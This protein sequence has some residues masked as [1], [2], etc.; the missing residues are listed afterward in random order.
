MRLRSSDDDAMVEEVSLSLQGVI[1]RWVLEISLCSYST[2][3]SWNKKD[4]SQQRNEI[5]HWLNP[6]LAAR[7]RN[8]EG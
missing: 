8:A 4:F 7:T 2:K 6:T 5:I 1:L 3:D